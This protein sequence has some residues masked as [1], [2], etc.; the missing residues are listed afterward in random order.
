MYFNCIFSVFGNIWFDITRSLV[1]PSFFI[2]FLVYVSSFEVFFVH[3]AIVFL[4]VVRVFRVLRNSGL[5]LGWVS[6]GTTVGLE[7]GVG[8][9]LFTD[10]SCS[11]GHTL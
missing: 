3:L 9:V 7:V 2:V 5:G 1:F 6:V 8:G 11:V 4:N 10:D